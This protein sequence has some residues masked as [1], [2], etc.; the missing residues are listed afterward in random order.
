MS[1]HRG[2]R[3]RIEAVRIVGVGDYRLRYLV[4]IQTRV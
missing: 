1:D 4:L 2:I 3:R